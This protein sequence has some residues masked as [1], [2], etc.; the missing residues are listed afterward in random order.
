KADRPAFGRTGHR[1]RPGMAE[2]AV[3]RIELLAQHALDV[4]DGVDQP[5]I[6]LDLPSPDDP[7]GARLADARFVVAV[8]VR[9]HRELALVLYGVE[10]FPDALGVFDWV[11]AAR[12]RAADRA[13]FDP[14]S[15]DPDIHFGRGSDQKLALAEVDQCAVGRRIGLAQA[16]KDDARRVGAKIGEELPGYDLEQVPALKGRPGPFDQRGV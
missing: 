9:A 11:A 7:H 3:E 8:D 16:V 2:E 13:G 10:Q 4:I 1:H 5:R 15:L 6:E 12:N 14:L